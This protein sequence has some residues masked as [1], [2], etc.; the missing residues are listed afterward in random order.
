MNKVSIKS[1]EIQNREN[2]LDQAL[3]KLES[4]KIK[5]MQKV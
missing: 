5:L 2:P 4:M 3:E 1:A